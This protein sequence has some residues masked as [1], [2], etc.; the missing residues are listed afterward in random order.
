MSPTPWSGE[1]FTFS[2]AGPHDDWELRYAG[3]LVAFWRKEHLPSDAVVDERIREHKEK[4]K[5]TT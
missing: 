3:E 4:Q 1:G 2:Q 5:K